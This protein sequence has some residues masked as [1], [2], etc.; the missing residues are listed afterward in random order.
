MLQLNVHVNAFHRV[1]VGEVRRCDEIERQLRY[2]HSELKQENIEVFDSDE[3]AELPHAREF[4]NLEVCAVK[5]W[6]FV[7]ISCFSCEL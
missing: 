6:Q 2:L 4:T 3:D 5:L 7:C 1:F